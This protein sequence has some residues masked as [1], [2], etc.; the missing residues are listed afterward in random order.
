MGRDKSATT[1]GDAEQSEMTMIA[2]PII[3]HAGHAAGRSR[4]WPC[5]ILSLAR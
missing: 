5:S 4:R 3:V 2:I 1:T